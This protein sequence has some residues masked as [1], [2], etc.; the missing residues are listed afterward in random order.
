[1]DK[2]DCPSKKPKVTVGFVG[3]TPTET[4]LPPPPVHGK[5]LVTGQGPAD[6]KLPILLREDSQY[7]FK[8]FSSIITS[9][10][11]EDLGNHSIEAMGEMGL[12][13]FA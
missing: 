8:Q 10:D 11:Y 2:T 12:F 4:K 3:V 6:E 1:M 7:A 5:G 13:S 9:E